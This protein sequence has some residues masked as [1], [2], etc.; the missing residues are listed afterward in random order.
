M[1]LRAGFQVSRCCIGFI[2]VI[3]VGLLGV[4]LAYAEPEG[5]LDGTDWMGFNADYKLAL[6]EGTQEELREQDMTTKHDALFYVIAVNEFY[7]DPD[8]LK[9]NFADAMSIIG[10]PLGD[11]EEASAGDLDEA[12]SARP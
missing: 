9:I 4:N 6:I 8:H 5:Y 11:F 7:S 1:S 10:F 12:Q 3:A 2:L